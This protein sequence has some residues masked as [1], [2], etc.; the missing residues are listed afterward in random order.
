MLGV[1]LW[2]RRQCGGTYGVFEGQNMSGVARWRY[3]DGEGDQKG[4]LLTHTPFN[5]LQLHS[6]LFL[7][8]PPILYSWYSTYELQLPIPSL[9][10]VNSKTLV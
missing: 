7:I 2:G 8:H 9:T 3:A 1:G 6:A 10:L 5:Q 4:C